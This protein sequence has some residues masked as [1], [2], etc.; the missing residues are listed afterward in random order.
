MAQEVDLSE[1]EG[2]F[3]RA[4]NKIMFDEMLQDQVIVAFVV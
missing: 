1:V 3:L 2:T 4:N